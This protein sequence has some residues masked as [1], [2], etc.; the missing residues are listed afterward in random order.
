R[1][2]ASRPRTRKASRSHGL[3]PRGSSHARCGLVCVATRF[4]PSRLLALC[5]SHCGGRHLARHGLVYRESRTL[6][7]FTVAPRGD[8]FAGFPQRS[9]SSGVP[10]AAFRKERFLERPSRPRSRSRDTAAFVP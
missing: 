1:L 4:L 5:R 10:L 8:A 9:C 2:A 7:L 6:G 3:T